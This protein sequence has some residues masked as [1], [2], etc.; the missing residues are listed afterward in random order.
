MTSEQSREFV[1]E[2]M[3]RLVRRDR[4]AAKEMF[5]PDA[6]LWA[7]GSPYMTRDQYFAANVGF[8]ERSAGDWD[9]TFGPLVAEGNRVA[10]QGESR[11][12]LRN[13]KLY[14]NFYHLYFEI[15]DAKIVLFREYHDTRHLQE[16][17][18]GEDPYLGQPVRYSPFTGRAP[19]VSRY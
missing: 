5:S 8:E 4:E 17:F 18:N 9:F 11:V 6:V 19:D 15:E 1:Q 16:C 12:R 7:T 3:R 14:N 10:L 2:Y 13:G